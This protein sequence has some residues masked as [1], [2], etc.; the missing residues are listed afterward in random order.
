MT[1]PRFTDPRYSDPPYSDPQLF[2]PVLPRDDGVG[3]T[4]GWLAGIMVVALIVPGNRRHERQ[5]QYRERQP[6][7]GRHR[8]GQHEPAQHHRFG[9]VVAAAADARADDAG[10]EQERYAV[11]EPRSARF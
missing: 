1:D 6:V 8:T 10:A 3:G 11:D 7:A 9:R 5:Q 4:W 2:D